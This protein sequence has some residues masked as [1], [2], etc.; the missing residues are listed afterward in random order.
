MGLQSRRCRRAFGS[1]GCCAHWADGGDNDSPV[2]AY[3]SLGAPLITG[4]MLQAC[5]C[6]WWGVEGAGRT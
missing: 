2:A 1:V 3:D 5:V 6:A 4:V